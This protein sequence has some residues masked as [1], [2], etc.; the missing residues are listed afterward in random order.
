MRFGHLT[1]GVLEHERA[2]AVEDSGRPAEDR[3]SVAPGL[4]AVAGCLDDDESDRRL[5]DEP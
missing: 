3:R 1:V 4:D 5:A 2:R